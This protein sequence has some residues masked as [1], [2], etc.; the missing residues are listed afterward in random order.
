MINIFGEQEFKHIVRFGKVLPKYLISKDGRL[1]SESS[2]K[3]LKAIPSYYTKADGTKRLSSVRTDLTI[4]EG[5][6]EDYSHQ[7]KS[8]GTVTITLRTHRAVMETWRPID[9]YP[10]IP[11]EDWDRC[12]ESAKQWIRDTAIVDHKDDDPTNNHVDNLQWVIPKDNN[13]H[14]KAHKHD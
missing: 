12:P 3:L 9:E 8:E 1:Y 5:L 7:S 13:P 11:K 14:R 4:P 10:P 6:F 2:G